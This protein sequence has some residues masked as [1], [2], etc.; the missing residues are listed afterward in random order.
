[1]KISEC[2]AEIAS[3]DVDSGHERSFFGEA[4]RSRSL[5]TSAFPKRRFCAALPFHGTSGI[6]TRMSFH[7][8]NWFKVD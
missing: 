5:I 8:G 1:M 2:N 4:R 7:F 3:S 6:S